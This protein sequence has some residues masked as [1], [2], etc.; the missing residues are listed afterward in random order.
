[1]TP[2]RTAPILFALAIGL[3]SEA[4]AQMPPGV[5]MAPAQEP[6]CMKD[7]QPL[8]QEAEK[9]ALA[10]R[11]G[12][13]KKVPREEACKLFQSFS[14]AEIKM[15]NY[16]KANATWCGI[17]PQALAQMEQGHANT[18]K[19]RTQVCAVGAA[20]PAAKPAAPSLSDA[21]GTSNAPIPEV[22]KG[23]G[24]TFNT[25]TGNALSR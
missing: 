22:S 16:A 25:M 20:G 17:P 6:P 11:A 15:I 23:S 1:M 9:R 2:L 4:A 8:R 10:I 5:G 3:A 12:M 18:V 7:F 21:L 14:A 13:E 24:G 19:A